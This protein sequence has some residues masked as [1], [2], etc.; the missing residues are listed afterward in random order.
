VWTDDSEYLMMIAMTGRMYTAFTMALAGVALSA[1]QSSV[2]TAPAST[3][4][5][6]AV[7]SHQPSTTIA[8]SLGVALA[9]AVPVHGIAYGTAS[10]TVVATVTGDVLF[11][12][13]GAHVVDRSRDSSTMAAVVAVD[14]GTGA[15]PLTYALR[16]GTSTMQPIGPATDNSPY[17]PGWAS[18]G[19]PSGCVHDARRKQS[20]L[21]LCSPDP[22]AGPTQLERM[23]NGATAQLIP[24]T[25]PQALGSWADAVEGPDGYIAATWSGDCES[26]TGYLITPDDRTIALSTNGGASAVLGWDN[27]GVLVARFAGCGTDPAPPALFLVRPDGQTSAVPTPD[28]IEA[29]VAW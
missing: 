20:T 18:N 16:L 29:P 19:A 12:I 4:A 27:G 8:A 7:Q 22:A 24:V 14:Q 21:L 9:G 15:K 11:R 13:A 3:T 28:A 2:A 1:C 10:G 5:R 17:V 26:L 25:P 6:T 23:T